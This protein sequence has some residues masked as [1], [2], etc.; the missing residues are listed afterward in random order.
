MKMELGKISL[1][2]PYRI[3]LIV[4]LCV[5][6]L[7]AS[8]LFL[9]SDQFREKG[10]LSQDLAHTQ[11]EV[12]RLTI[13]KNSMPEGRK[14]YV[15]LQERLQEAIRE[16][17]EQKE[18]P[19]LLRQVSMTAQG[20][21][22]RIKF[23]APKEIQPADFYSELPFEIKYSG[24]YHSL[25]YFFDGIRHMERIVRVTSF[26]LEAKGTGQKVQLEG[27]CLAK[28][29]VFQKEPKP[30]E[31]KDKKKDDKNAPAPK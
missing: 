7:V 6:I 3:P 29:Y 25:G 19:N 31:S 4:L 5:A 8:Y 22:T 21:R 16:M 30:K 28:T 24:L 1:P 26:S 23:F 13:I 20:S 27:S 9:L 12:A 17:P 15:A 11:Q 2:K 14:Q 18:I 10:R